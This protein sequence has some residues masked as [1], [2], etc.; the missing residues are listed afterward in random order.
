MQK[1]IKDENEKK[2]DEIK[3]LYSLYRNPKKN[4][5]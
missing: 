2:L 1:R 4:C 3:V 5:I